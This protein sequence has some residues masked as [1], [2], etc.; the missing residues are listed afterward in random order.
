MTLYYEKRCAMCGERFEATRWHA[1]LC[2]DR[3]RQRSSRARRAQVAEVGPVALERAP[4]SQ[5]SAGST[6]G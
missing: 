2:S 1:R 6:N 4:L 5:N 3:C